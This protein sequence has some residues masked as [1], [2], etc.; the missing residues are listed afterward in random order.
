V[1]GAGVCVTGKSGEKILRREPMNDNPWEDVYHRNGHV[2]TE[3]HTVVPEFANLLEGHGQ[4]GKRF[5]DVGCGN[6]RH[7]VYFSKLGYRV[8]GL[9]SSPSAIRLSREWLERDELNGNLLLSDSRFP[10]PVA[11]VSFDVLISTQV[12]HHALLETVLFTIREITRV[13]R[14]GGFIL[15]SVPVFRE[16]SDSEEKWE[17]IERHTFVPLSGIE[18]GLPHHLFTLDEFGACF[19]AF[20]VL[21]LGEDGNGHI[22]LTGRKR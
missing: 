16:V 18:K 19:P 6:G 20:D 11:N 15:I 17:E 7:L 9:D 21:S 13:V 14:P 3:I 8:I 2:F 4:T 1:A 5:L 22:V 10:F 12:I